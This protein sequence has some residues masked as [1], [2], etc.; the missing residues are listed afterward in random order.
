MKRQTRKR[1]D[2]FHCFVLQLGIGKKRLQIGDKHL[3]TDNAVNGTVGC[4]KRNC[5]GNGRTVIP[6]KRV[7]QNRPAT[8]IIRVQRTVICPC[9][10][11][12]RCEEALSGFCVRSKEVV[13]DLSVEIPMERT[14]AM[15]ERSR[16]KIVVGC[17]SRGSGIQI[18]QIH[19][20]NCG[21]RT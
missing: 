14:S 19:A 11:K 12:N 16:K 4:D 5:V 13:Q 21:N 17:G 6:G 2:T 7:G 3:D 9:G 15:G 10:K 8:V 18:P 20:R 1:E